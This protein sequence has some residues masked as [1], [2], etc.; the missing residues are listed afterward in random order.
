MF[1]DRTAGQP[2]TYADLEGLMVLGGTNGTVRNAL[3]Y[4]EVTVQLQGDPRS[5]RDR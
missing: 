3:L 5:R 1:A 4:E 2:F